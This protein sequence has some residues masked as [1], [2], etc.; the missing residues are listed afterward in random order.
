MVGSGELVNK[1]IAL[2]NASSR[3][4]HAWASLAGTL[5]GMSAHVIVEASIT[6][7]LDGRRLDA[8]G[9]VGDAELSTAL[10]SAIEAL[11]GAARVTT[12]PPSAST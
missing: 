8:N 12:S 9:I 1:P 2:I 11:A 7:P 10:R 3:A 4:T 6:V 5:A